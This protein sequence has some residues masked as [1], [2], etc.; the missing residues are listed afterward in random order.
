MHVLNKRLLETAWGKTFEDQIR[1][2]KKLWALCLRFQPKLFLKVS[3]LRHACMLSI[4]IMLKN[5]SQVHY[6]K[7]QFSHKN[8]VKLNDDI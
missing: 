8:C 5:Q 7:F 2:N 4:I 6:S 3:Y 1:E